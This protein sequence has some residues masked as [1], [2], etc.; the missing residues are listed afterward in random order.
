MPKT[1]PLTADALVA[2]YAADIAF[3][4]DETPATNTGDFIQQLYTAHRTLSDRSGISLADDLDT[5]A[6]YLTDAVQPDNT[7]AETQALLRKAADLMRDIP[8]AVG[9]YRLA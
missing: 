8:D 3:A 2:R 5:A 1:A 6:I 4:A 9:E 7:D